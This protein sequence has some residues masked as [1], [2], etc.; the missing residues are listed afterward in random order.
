MSPPM[1]D[2]FALPLVQFLE[3]TETEAIE[4]HA[5]PALEGDFLQPLGRRAT[6]FHLEGFFVGETEAAALKELRD[7]HRAAEPVSFVADIATAT[8]VG[9]VLIETF[10]TREIA[11]FPQRTEFKLGLVEYIPAPPPKHEQ[12]PQ[13]PPPPPPKPSPI[14]TAG[15]LEVTV[16]VDGEPNFD[17]STIVVRVDAKPTSGDPFQATLTDRKA[18]VWT[19]SPTPPGTYTATAATTTHVPPLTGSAMGNVVPPP[20]PPTRLEIH[21]KEGPVVG[22]GFIVHY[23]FDKAF[24]EP[25]LRDVLRDVA[26]FAAAHPDQKMLIVG[27]T[28]LAGSDAYNQALSERRARGVYAYLTAGRAHDAAVA[29]WDALRRHGSAVTRLEDNWGVREYQWILFRLGFYNGAIDERNGPLTDAAV[30]RFQSAHGLTSDG[31]VGDDTWLALI[32]AYLSTDGQ[33]IPESQFFANCPGEIVKWLGS[34]ERD[35][36]RSD[37]IVWRPDRRAEIVFVAADALPGKVERPVTFDLPTPGA[38]N[39]G[40]CVGPSDGS[41]QIVVLSHKTPQS[42]TIF[43]QP[44]DPRT[45][46]VRGRMTLENTSATA[47]SGINYVL[48]APDGEFL[49]G[50]HEKDPLAGRPVPGTTDPQGRFSYGEKGAGIYTLQVLGPFTARLKSAAPNSGTSPNL[51]ARL[52]GSQD[53]DIVL[54][55]VAAGG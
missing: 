18:N 15:G 51:C 29:E 19:R 20:D 24:V 45:F 52:D 40:W 11:G 55:P 1:L 28:D 41:G 50:E 27:N 30:R 6:R 53:L 5:V 42:N 4:E 49:G 13:P 7:K 39:S 35:P 36:V 47:A 26:V 2:R 16:I 54:A 37:R 33:S 46:P 9:T 3:E 17:F 32:D 8:K 10:E 38:T 25:C 12:P 31:F 43:V 48:T 21:L 34:G 14:P 22:T 44:A 23:W